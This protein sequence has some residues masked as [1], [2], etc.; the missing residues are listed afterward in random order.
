VVSPARVS[1]KGTLGRS[2][3]PWPPTTGA[4]CPTTLPGGVHTLDFGAMRNRRRGVQDEQESNP[5][6]P[7]RARR[8][9]APQAQVEGKGPLNGS[10]DH[11]VRW[12]GVEGQR[13]TEGSG[14]V[15]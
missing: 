7:V 1:R 8:L 10:G 9:P 4:F 5:H 6:G 11:R 12:K 3:R 15:A 14:V 13:L 2:S